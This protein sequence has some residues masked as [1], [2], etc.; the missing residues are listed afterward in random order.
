MSPAE[1]L[2]AEIIPLI[3]QL[4]EGDLSVD[5]LRRLCEGEG[6]ALREAV[7]YPGWFGLVRDV[8]VGINLYHVVAGGQL[9]R[10]S[11]K[12]RKRRTLGRSVL[13]RLERLMMR[14]SAPSGFASQ[15]RNVQ[16]PVNSPT[17]SF[18]HEVANGP[19][20]ERVAFVRYLGR[21]M[22]IWL[23]CGK[24]PEGFPSLIYER[25]SEKVWVPA[26]RVAGSIGAAADIPIPHSEI[27]SAWSTTGPTAPRS[28]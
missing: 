16:S 5:V 14:R 27:I 6:L 4:P 28:A 8:N 19:N 18:V 7:F 3:N 13:S 12:Y 10:L 24:A 21:V 9:Q 11:H 26:V 2:S 23:D 1:D 20:D 25:H 15:S 17:N 22:S